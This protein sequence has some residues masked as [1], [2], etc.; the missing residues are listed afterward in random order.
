MTVQESEKQLADI[1]R[2]A[3]VAERAKVASGIDFPSMAIPILGM[4]P[5]LHSARRRSW[6]LKLWGWY[7]FRNR[8][9][10]PSPND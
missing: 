8:H 5:F 2:R 9:G 7:R 3:E 4:S 10:T 6:D 1:R